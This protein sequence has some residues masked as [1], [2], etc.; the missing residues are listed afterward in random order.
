MGW[1]KKIRRKIVKVVKNVVKAP[2]RAAKAIIKG[3]PKEALG[4]MINPFTSN[5]EKRDRWRRRAG[6]MTVGAIGGF[7]ASGGNPLGA[8]AGA[9]AGYYK[10]RKGG[11][12]QSNLKGYG[13]AALMGAGTGLAVAYGPGALKW[14]GGKLT[15]GSLLSK[16]KGAPALGNLA[17]SFTGGGPAGSAG[18][19]MPDGS[20]MPPEMFAGNILPFQQGA[21]SVTQ[22]YSQTPEA[23]PSLVLPAVI[24]GSLILLTKAA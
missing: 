1:F 4:Y 14:A 11:K 17:S 9:G 23:K 2:F 19:M 16:L 10:F 8:V 20:M 7:V 6:A 15:G 13:T 18:Y 5:A 24:V 12:G 3:K 21:G 22:G